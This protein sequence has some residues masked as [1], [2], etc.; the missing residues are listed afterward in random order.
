MINKLSQLTI[1]KFIDLVCGDAGV[2][3][4]PTMIRKDKIAVIIR[5]IVFEYKEIADPIG[6]KGYLFEMEEIAK[7][8]LTVLMYQICENLMELGQYD[9]VREILSQC[10][11]NVG[12]MTENRL[13]AEIKSRIERARG[14]IS[15]I[16][17]DIAEPKHDIDIRK[18]FDAQTAA[19]MAY[20]KFQ[21]DPSK[22]SASIYAHLVA[23]HNR[24]VKAQLAAMKK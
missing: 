23:R 22:M 24:E 15:K 12:G 6:I 5:N 9:K 17:E 16:E 4:A 14:T 20:F 18:E 8:K 7:S 21:I 13:R 19:L 3:R 1:A 2:L 10:G 11:Y